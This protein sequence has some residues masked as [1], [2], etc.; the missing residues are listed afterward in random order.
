[1][2]LER[3]EEWK[4]TAMIQ[5]LITML[6]NVL[7][8]FIDE[9]PP[10]L[11]KAVRSASCERSLGLGAMGFHALLQSKGM[12]FESAQAIGLN[13][14]IFRRIKMEAV[15]ASQKL[16]VQRGEF[17]DGWKSG[18]RNSHLLAI[19]PNANSSMIVSTSPS[20]EPWKS[21]AFT[22]RTRVGAH[23]IRN[24]YLN[25]RIEEH[26]QFEG[27]PEEWCKEQWDSIIHNE[28]SVQQLSWMSEWDKSV[29]KTA[30]E[31]DQGWVV[32]HAADRQEWICQGQSV[33]LFF[34]SG[35][36]RSYVNQVH[37][38]AFKKKLKGL[39]YLRTSSG[40]IAE[41]VGQRVERV[42]LKDHQDDCMGCQ[43]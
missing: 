18:M 41:Q 28:G 36:D 11:Y 37:L 14:R 8:R 6:D 42:A 20:I 30:F 21:N 1:V 34:P 27:D 15:E 31:I 22:H 39:Y 19:A 38:K 26:A 25:M 5:D 32:Q 13:R 23:L 35:S 33:N 40:Q 29:F 43:G 3:W 2:N 24:K 4:N 12:P 7:D 17:K 10:E 9:A 16:A